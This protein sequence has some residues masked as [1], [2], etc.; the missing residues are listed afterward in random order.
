MQP[1]TANSKTLQV[2]AL[3]LIVFSWL[4]N[5][6]ITAGN[7]HNL[8]ASIILL[9][10]LFAVY[11]FIYKQGVLEVLAQAG[12]KPVAVRQVMLYATVVA[13]A[14]FLLSF[15]LALLL[16]VD[17]TSLFNT[18]KASGV[19]TVSIIA[20]YR[21][22]AALAAL[23]VFFIYGTFTEELVFRGLLLRKLLKYN[24]VVANVVQALL[25]GLLH[26]AVALAATI[27]SSYSVF[28]FTLPFL[29]ALLLGY[30]TKRPTTIW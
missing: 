2:G 21:G 18:Q 24:F 11:K 22:V 3:L 20:R 12:I 4:V 16:H 29:T 23:V 5:N 30:P 15:V 9:V 28:I 17:L 7:K 6:L 13:S 26:W 27:P 14:S 1:K 10:L 25:F 8:D 19:G